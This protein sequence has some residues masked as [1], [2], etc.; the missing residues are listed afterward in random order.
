MENVES[1]KNGMKNFMAIGADLSTNDKLS[2]IMSK[3]IIVLVVVLTLFWFINKTTLKDRN[4]ASIASLY[5]DNS[6]K[7]HSIN[8]NSVEQYSLRDY[9]IKTA[10]NC[11]ATGQFKNDFVDACALKNVIKQGARC[12]DFE[13]YTV[14]DE[15]VVA[16]SSTLDRSIKETYNSMQFSSVLSTIM[17]NAFSSGGCANSNDPLILHLRMKT[18]IEETYNKMAEIIKEKIEP[19]GRL[20]DKEYSYEFAGE[21]G[22]QNLGAEPICNFLE[23]V[24]IIVNKSDSNVVLENTE[25]DEFTNMC[26]GEV[27]MRAQNNHDIQYASNV[28]EIKQYNKTCMT[29]CMPDLSS[30]NNNINSGMAMSLGCQMVAMNFPNFDSN[31]EHYCYIFDKAGTAFV[32]KPDYLRYTP[33]NIEA[34]T[35]IPDSYNFAPR[36]LSFYGQDYTV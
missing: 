28:E 35:E 14:N 16:T 3:F 15:P 22:S 36:K 27:F 29:L 1:L 19:S 11:C 10:Y 8:S 17:N 31:I 33:N 26:S 2:G 24:I 20:L 18:N 25:L 4:C 34:P 30:N 13:I 7:L 6:N 32:V 21:Q 12:L 9:Y 23:K 5:A